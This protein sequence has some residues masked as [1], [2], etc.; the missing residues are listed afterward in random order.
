MLVR[1]GL[2]L[3]LPLIGAYASATLRPIPRDFLARSASAPAPQTTAPTPA[4]ET[5]R[6]TLPSGVDGLRAHFENGSAMFIDARTRAEFEAGHLSGALHLPFEAFLSGRPDMLDFLMEDFPII[7]YCGGGDCDASHQVE[8]MLR[9][10]GYEKVSVFEPGWPLI[11]ESGL[12]VVE[13]SG[14]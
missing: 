7:I 6:P 13:G 14:M 10:Y 2:L 4:M 5:A 1:L 12:P 3:L 9:S 8:R 11:L